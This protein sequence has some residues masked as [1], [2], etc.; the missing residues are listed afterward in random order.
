MQKLPFPLVV[1]PVLVALN[2]G[3]AYQKDASSPLPLAD[4]ASIKLIGAPVRCISMSQ[5]DHSDVIDDDTIDFHIGR[6]I[7]RNRLQ[8]SCPGLKRDD[9]ILIENRTGSLCS[10]D[11]VYTLFDA[12]GQLQ[13]GTPCGLGE[14]Q[15]IEK[16]KPQK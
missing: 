6:K 10:V 15:Q 3:C 4:D 7:Y 13:R 12:G 1:L 16:V 14:F 5:M 11:V 9:R 2:T 8:S